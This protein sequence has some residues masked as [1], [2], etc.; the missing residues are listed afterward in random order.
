[1][2]KKVK[3][4]KAINNVSFSLKGIDLNPLREFSKSIIYISINDINKL[5]QEIQNVSNIIGTCQGI[6]ENMS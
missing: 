2:M 4:F 6:F 1:M 5:H 3:T